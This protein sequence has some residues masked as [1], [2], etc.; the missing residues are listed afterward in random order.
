MLENLKAANLKRWQNMKVNESAIPSL[1]KI[2]KRLVDA[3][4]RYKAVEAQTGVP[5]FVIAVIHEREAS[6]S[7]RAN[8]AQ[9]DP[10]NQVSTHVPRGQG[11]FSSWEEA[12]VNALKGDK[13]T[14]W[15]D[16]SIGGTLAALEKYNGLGYVNKGQPSPYVWAKTNQYTS[17]KYVADGVYDP[18]AVDKQSGCAALIA[19]M[20]LMDPSIEFGKPSLVKPKVKPTDGTGAVITTVLAGGGLAAYFKDHIPEIAIGALVLAFVAWIVVRW[21]K[22]NVQPRMDI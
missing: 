10:W 20:K 12:A 11:P 21:Y 16:W 5:W 17:G 22:N 7:W 14:T 3:K 2:A 15:G 18:N 4:D 9:G 13:L 8:L 19:R 1:D 6:Q